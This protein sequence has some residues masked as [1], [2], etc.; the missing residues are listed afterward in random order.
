MYFLIATMLIK[1]GVLG[2]GEPAVNRTVFTFVELT[3]SFRLVVA[4]QED[5]QLVARPPAG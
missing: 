4:N 3:F 5:C 1:S 2:R